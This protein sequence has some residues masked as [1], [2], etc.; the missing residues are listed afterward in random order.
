[1]QRSAALCAKNTTS[2]VSALQ[3]PEVA[4]CRLHT[5]TSSAARQD[6][7]NQSQ[8]PPNQPTTNSSSCC[9]R[10]PA[11]HIHP[12]QAVFSIALVLYVPVL[13]AFY[14][15]AEECVFA[16]GYQPVSDPDPIAP[17]QPPSSVQF[18]TLTN[19]AFLVRQDMVY[20]PNCYCALRL[21]WCCQQVAHVRDARQT[22]FLLRRQRVGGIMLHSC[23]S[24]GGTYTH[25]HHHASCCDSRRDAL[26]RLH[27]C[28]DACI[29]S[30]AQVTRLMRPNSYPLE[31]SSLHHAAP[32]SLSAAYFSSV[33]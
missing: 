27:M 28:R 11:C 20:V 18:M 26:V 29:I 21:L 23:S 15:A 22:Y 13:I 3:T 30:S 17:P 25:V 19:M 14:S 1:M 33:A 31:V 32:S 5:V 8:L 4:G 9:S 10:M 6:D 2:F 7:C 16:A 12:H 24:T